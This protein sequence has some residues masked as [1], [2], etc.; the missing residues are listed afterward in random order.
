MLTY[1]TIVSDTIDVVLLAQEFSPISFLSIAS[2]EK[3]KV[4][5]L[6]SLHYVSDGE[7]ARCIGIIGAR[8][9]GTAVDINP[10]QLFKISKATVPSLEAF[11]QNQP[12]G[13]N[14][15]E[16]R[17]TIETKISN[18]IPIPSQFAAL[19]LKNTPNNAGT[20]LQKILDSIVGEDR[21]RYRETHSDEVEPQLSD[22][23]ITA[24]HLPLLQHLHAYANMKSPRQAGYSLSDDKYANKWVAEMD[25]QLLSNKSIDIDDSDEEDEEDPDKSDGETPRTDNVRPQ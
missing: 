9:R 19:V 15:S 16:I 22:M 5:S 2:G 6:H 14:A 4:I 11:I 23:I 17:A 13:G 8:N 7:D 21:F 25:A 20:I 12:S 18:S 24:A 1:P 3:H 10:Q